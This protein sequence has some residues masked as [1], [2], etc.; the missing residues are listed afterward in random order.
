M[1]D[2]PYKHGKNQ[3]QST[4]IRNSF[5]LGAGILLVHIYIAISLALHFGENVY[6]NLKWRSSSFSPLNTVSQF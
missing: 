6:R 5:E 4:E 3:P 1:A 2:F